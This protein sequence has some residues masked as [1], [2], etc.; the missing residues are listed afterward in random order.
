MPVAAQKQ[1]VAGFAQTGF[2]TLSQ[3]AKRVRAVSPI[4]LLRTDTGNDRSKFTART[5]EANCAH[6]VVLISVPAGKFL[7][8]SFKNCCTKSLFD[9]VEFAELDESVDDEPLVDVVDVLLLN[10]DSN[11]ERSVVDELLVAPDALGGG[12]PGAPL[13]GAPNSLCSLDVSMPLAVRT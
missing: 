2:Q 3:S 7:N 10:D 9:C 11:D 4:F 8:T 13:G 12:P 6:A 5:R 1:Y